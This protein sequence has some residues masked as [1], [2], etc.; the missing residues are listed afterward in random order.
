MLMKRQFGRAQQGFSLI[1]MLIV[2]AILSLVLGAIFNTIQDITKKYKTEESRVN[3]TQ[4]SREFL[5]QI[6]RD[7]HTSG[8][9]N[10][11]MYM[12]ATLFTSGAIP[13]ICNEGKI[14]FE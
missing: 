2:C 3:E 7:L 1:E 4:E 14:V 10:T 8:Y 13:M 12:P 5:D 6:V 9:P 11:K